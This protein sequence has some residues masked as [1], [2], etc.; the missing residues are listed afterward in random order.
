MFK[1]F[2]LA[3]LSTAAV[4]AYR[5]AKAGSSSMRLQARSKA[6]PF[7]DAPAKLDGKTV[8][9]F[10][11]DPL[12]FTN[13]LNDLNYVQAAEI[14]HGRVAMLAT[15]GFVLQQY[16]HILSPES[17]PLK[18]VSSV[19]TGVNLQVLSFIGVLEL[20]TWK[21]TFQGHSAGKN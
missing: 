4:S 18:A 9:D 11:F 20:V 13:T 2:L 7:V 5:V 6:I 15:V 8:G 17:N 3:L 1:L 14:K 21:A 16:I 10:G 19:G 12:G